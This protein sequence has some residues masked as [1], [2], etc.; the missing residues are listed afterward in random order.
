[1]HFRALRPDIQTLAPAYFGLP[2]STGA[3]ALASHALGN[4][5]IA[6]FL[7]GLNKVELAVLGLLLLLRVVFFFPHFRADLAAPGKGAGFLTVVAALCI[8]GTEQMLM[9][10][11]A[12]T[13]LA[14]WAVAFIVWLLLSYAFFILVTISTKKPG[15]AHGINGT[16]L[17]FVVA[18]QAL[19][20]LAC[21]LAPLVAPHLRHALFAA[22]FLYL[23]GCLFYV[24]VIG[25]IFYRTAFFRMRADEFKPSYW[26]DM[27]AAAITTLAGTMLADAMARHGIYTDFIPMLKLGS[28]FFWVAGTWWIPVILILEVWR[29]TIIP[30]RYQAGQWSLV[31]PLGVYT[32]CTWELAGMLQLPV[33]QTVSWVFLRIAWLAWSVT[34]LGMAHRMWKRYGARQG[35]TSA[36]G[37]GNR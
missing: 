5:G 17:L 2:M 35:S 19:S 8:L 32:L 18:A 28:A 10:S 24:V 22:L 6:H 16:W 31:F 25:M 12:F 9:A 21:L 7:F 11:G 29:Y 23:L 34:F 13:V 3:L 27:G 15:L 33:L 37:V 26:I 14:L 30:L 1:M 4:E 20:I 36:P